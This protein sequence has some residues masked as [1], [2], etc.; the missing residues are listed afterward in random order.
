MNRLTRK[1]LTA[2]CASA[3]IG[4]L[5]V[6]ASDVMRPAVLPQQGQPVDLVIALDVSS[7]MSGLIESAKQRLWD[8]VN[9]VAQAQPAPDLRLAVITYGN[10]AYGADSGYVRIDQPFTRDL[11]AVMK[12]LFSFGTNGGDEFVARAVDTSVRSLSWSRRGDALKILFVAGNES[13]EQD[14][15]ITVQAAT[16]LAAN[17]GIVVNTIYCGTDGGEITAG[18]QRVATLT[19]GLYASIDQNAAALANIATPMDQK[20]AE[21]NQQLNETY[22]AYGE[23]GALYKANQ[24]EQDSNAAA[25]SLPSAAS[26]AV[27][28]AGKLYRNESWD[29]VDAVA[30]GKPV[31]DLATEDLPEEM[32]SLSEEER[33]AYVSELAGKRDAISREIEAL[34]QERQ[35]YIAVERRK[36]E[37]SGADGLDEAILNALRDLARK[38]GFK[39][40]EAL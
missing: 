12:T 29:L 1:L 30:A 24:R 20:I 38:K 9:E 31:A 10:P 6:Q 23:Q 5:Q 18:W 37:Q 33:Q 3:L 21:L 14:P 40:D 27:A 2:C 11:D 34:G 22:V 7:S 17:H 4:T 32:Q 28:K 19:N 15:L 16:E 8:I 39:F 25:M 35:A 36:L 26:R 13:A